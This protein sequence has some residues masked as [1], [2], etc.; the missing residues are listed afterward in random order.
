GLEL[1]KIFVKIIQDRLKAHFTSSG[2]Q[3]VLIPY[4][5]SNNAYSLLGQI[6]NNE[7]WGVKYF[8]NEQRTYVIFQTPC[9]RALGSMQKKNKSKIK[10]V[11]VDWYQKGK[12][13]L[14]KHMIWARYISFGFSVVRGHCQQ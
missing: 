12:T 13:D 1:K 3:R 11:V 7:Q 9:E 6:L 4:T 10:Q 14:H 5:L 8:S 2:S